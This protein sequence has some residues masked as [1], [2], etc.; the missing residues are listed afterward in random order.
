MGEDGGAF[1]GFCIV[2]S[3]SRFLKPFLFYTGYISNNSS[4]PKPLSKEEEEEYLNLYAK[5]DEEA[6]NVLIERNLRLVAHMVKNITILEK[7]QMI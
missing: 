5:G 7:T 3:I 2:A 4:F 6:R 1:M